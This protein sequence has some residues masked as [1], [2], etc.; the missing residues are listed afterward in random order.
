VEHVASFELDE[1]FSDDAEDDYSR[2]D[3]RVVLSLSCENW[4]P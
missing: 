4:H 3:L 1:S 2:L